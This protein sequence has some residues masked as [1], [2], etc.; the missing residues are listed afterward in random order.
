MI[1]IASSYKKL[2]KFCGVRFS[3]KRALQ[4]RVFGHG[5][6]I[7]SSSSMHGPPDREAVWQ[8]KG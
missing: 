2:V 6:R 8:G 5:F 7:P 3:S 4:K 1:R